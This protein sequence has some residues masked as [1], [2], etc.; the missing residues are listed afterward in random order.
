MLSLCTGISFTPP[1]LGQPSKKLYTVEEKCVEEMTVEVIFFSGRPGCYLVSL[2]AFPY[3]RYDAVCSF[4]LSMLLAPPI[5]RLTVDCLRVVIWD[6]A[7]CSWFQFLDVWSWNNWYDSFIRSQHG[8][9]ACSLNVLILLFF[10]SNLVTDLSDWSQWLFLIYLEM[11]RFVP[12][13]A[14]S[15]YMLQ[16][17]R[18]DASKWC[19]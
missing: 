18:L 8:V 10:L 14:H 15:F 1:F 19:F 3:N 2:R 17:L 6:S 11:F 7:V 4:L 16:L 9:L 5:V 12:N 13:S